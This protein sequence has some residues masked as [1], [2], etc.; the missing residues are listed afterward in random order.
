[1][2]SWF[3]EFDAIQ[4]YQQ[5]NRD[6]FE[7]TLFERFVCVCVCVAKTELQKPAYN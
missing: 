2:Y 6:Q 5:S 7:H 3:V 1:M 4:C